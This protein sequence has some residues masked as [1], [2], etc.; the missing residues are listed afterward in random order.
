[1]LHK[2]MP[3][4]CRFKQCHYNFIAPPELSQECV[5]CE[6]NRSGRAFQRAL[7]QARKTEGKEKAEEVSYAQ[8]Q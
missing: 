6:G 8:K 4:N 2:L 3:N 5:G 7:D 1:M